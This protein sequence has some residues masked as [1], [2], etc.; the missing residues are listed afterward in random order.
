MP[1]APFLVCGGGACQPVADAQPVSA[2]RGPSKPFGIEIMNS[3]RPSSLLAQPAGAWLARSVAAALILGFTVWL[4]L[5]LGRDLNW[6]FFNY[7]YYGPH[8]LLEARLGHDYFAGSLQSYLNPTVHI[9]HYLMIQAGWRA[10]YIAIVLT[11]FHALNLLFIW[12]IA[13]AVLPSVGPRSEALPLLA[14]LLALAA[15]LFVTTA[16]SS[17]ADPTTSVLVLAAV[18]LLLRKP[19]HGK[20]DLRPVTVAGLLLGLASGLKLTNAILSIGIIL[21]VVVSW[22]WSRGTR[23]LIDSAVL[24]AACAGGV[25][26]AHGY[27]SWNLWDQFGNPFFPLFNG[28]VH[29]PDFP[30]TTFRDTRF[31]GAGWEGLLSLPFQMMFPVSWLY[32]ENAPV[33]LRFAAWLVLMGAVLLVLLARRYRSGGEAAESGFVPLLTLTGVFVVSYVLWGLSSRIGRYALPLWMLLGPLLLA[34]LYVLFRRLDFTILTGSILLAAQTAALVQTGNPRWSPAYWDGPWLSI[35]VPQEL[36]RQPVRLLTLGMQTYSAIVP[37][38]HPESR[39]ANLVGQH[40]QPS[41]PRMTPGLSRFMAGKEPEFRVAFKDLKGLAQYD[42][43]LADSTRR[44]ISALL[45]SYGLRLAP[46]PCQAIEVPTA[47]MRSDDN[48]PPTGPARFDG[49]RLHVCELESMAPSEAAAVQRDRD[50]IAKAFDAVELACGKSL[51][52]HGT[53]LL[54][55]HKGWMRTYFNSLHSLATDGEVVYV[56]P[57]RSMTD[58]QLGAL[59]LWLDAEPDVCPRLPGAIE[60]LR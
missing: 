3:S 24:A 27:W 54:R 16:G 57:F 10:Q 14:V 13:N 43:H 44:D 53:E 38:L 9:P 33:D 58:V 7:H 32:A 49:E 60:L 50:R 2:L 30:A 5:Q 35:R 6:D 18:W 48:S 37:A 55:G 1:K 23:A 25:I 45:S 19:S 21:P 36:A 4:S 40:V 51:S 11:S 15:P 41:G 52:P 29:A 56:R 22:M 28:V 12:L 47:Y 39:V 26:A 20:G 59:E 46:K 31:L 17:F 34:W 42:P 8:Q